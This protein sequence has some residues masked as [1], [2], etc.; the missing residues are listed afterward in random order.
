MLRACSNSKCS[1]QW[2][3][4]WPPPLAMHILANNTQCVLK[5]L[6]NR[7][8]KFLYIIRIILIVGIDSV[9]GGRTGRITIYSHLLSIVNHCNIIYHVHHTNINLLYDLRKQKTV[10]VY[11]YSRFKVNLNLYCPCPILIEMGFSLSQCTANGLFGF[12]SFLIL[13]PEVYCLSNSISDWLITG[14]LYLV[15]NQNQYSKY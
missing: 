7:P 6:T 3:I 1:K 5:N 12:F 13:T 9:E 10:R 14:H 15:T 2:N 8:M 11:N 4:T